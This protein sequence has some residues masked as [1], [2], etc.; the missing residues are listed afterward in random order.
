MA[1][2]PGTRNADLSKLSRNWRCIAEPSSEGD[3]LGAAESCAKLTG[4]FVGPSHTTFK[5][6]KMA[7][8]ASRGD[9]CV[10]RSLLSRGCNHVENA[11]G[12]PEWMASH[13]H[14]VQATSAKAPRK[15][16]SQRVRSA[17]SGQKLAG[18]TSMYTKKL[19]VLIFKHYSYD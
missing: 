18:N 9:I 19:R 5:R 16:S 6:G 10:V 13:A 4:S 11:A 12:R 8:C 15:V 3:I 14:N 17:D 7:C 2:L 1:K